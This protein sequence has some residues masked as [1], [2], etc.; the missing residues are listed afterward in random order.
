M[1]ILYKTIVLPIVFY[2]REIWPLALMKDYGLSWVLRR[3]L[4]PERGEVTGNQKIA[5]EEVL[6]NLYF[7]P[8]STSAI[9]SRKIRRA[10]DEACMRR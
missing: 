2:W 5:Y 4:Q 6:Y 3:I 7:L 9:I 1:R 8:N 10:G